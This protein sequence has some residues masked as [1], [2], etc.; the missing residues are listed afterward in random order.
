M[1][2]NF[3]SEMETGKIA[4][5]TQPNP[6]KPIFIIIC[7]PNLAYFTSILLKSGLK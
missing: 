2:E 6:T 1:S 4:T 3:S 7:K 5:W